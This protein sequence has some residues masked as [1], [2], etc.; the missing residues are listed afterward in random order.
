M[1]WDDIDISHLARKFSYYDRRALGRTPIIT[2]IADEHEVNA[3]ELRDAIF[4]EK[5]R[6]GLE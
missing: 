5:Q 6:L 1:T 2:E 3:V 4:K